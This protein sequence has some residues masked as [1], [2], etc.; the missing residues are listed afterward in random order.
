M[1]SAEWQSRLRDTRCR[2]SILAVTTCAA[3]AAAWSFGPHPLLAI[4]AGVL[5]LAA[6]VVLRI[7]FLVCLMFI[8]FSFFRIHEVFP[9]LY[10]LRIPQMLAMAALAVLGWHMLVSRQIVPVWSKQLVLFAAF[11]LLVTL[12]MALATNKGA[13]FSAWSGN[14][15]KIAVMTFAITWLTRESKDFALAAR[16]FVVC[17]IAVGL[18]AISNKMAGIGLV[19]GTRVSIGRSIG[20]VLGDPNDLALVLLFPASFALALLVTRG[21]KALDRLLGAV[22]I[23]V[24]TIAVIATQSRG[25]LLGIAAVFGVVVLRL[26]KSR[27]LVLVLGGISLPLLFAV[28]GIA[29]RASGGV[30]E[31]GL[32]ESAMGR[33][34]AWEAAA[35]MALAHPFTGVGLNNFYANYFFYSPHW[36]GL[37]HAVHSTWFGVLAETG[38]LGFLIFV[39]MITSMMISIRRSLRILATVAPDSPRFE[40]HVQVMALAIYS[41][42]AGFLV[43]GTFLTQ[44]FTWP[45]YILLALTVATAQMVGCLEPIATRESVCNGDGAARSQNA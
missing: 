17:G 20:S 12:G 40:P 13:A 35:N 31:E 23:S 16:C 36:D 37:N 26:V 41:G 9:Q 24:I 43:S 6:V 19:E 44:G 7:P 28:A 18:V 45:L 32:G 29:E 30:A 1:I 39:L 14:Y 10:S 3:V 42:L 4:V 11:F 21:T 5:P 8:V 27:S 33:L 15:V 38:M 25:G 34:Y 22:G 2:D